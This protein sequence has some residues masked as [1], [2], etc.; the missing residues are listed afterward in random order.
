[1]GESGNVYTHSLVSIVLI[2]A[3]TVTCIFLPYRQS[4]DQVCCSHPNSF[5]DR[6][7]S[8][9]LGCLCL[10]TLLR[11]SP[12][13]QDCACH[14]CVCH[15]GSW[16]LCAQATMLAQQ[17]TCMSE[18]YMLRNREVLQ[19]LVWSVRKLTQTKEWLGFSEFVNNTEQTP[20]SNSFQNNLMQP[21]HCFEKI[22]VDGKTYSVGFANK[23]NNSPTFRLAEATLGFLWDS[24]ACL[25]PAIWGRVKVLTGRLHITLCLWCS[26]FLSSAMVHA[27]KHCGAFCTN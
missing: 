18:P 14:M 24:T 10:H 4:M 6:C 15:L 5:S 1:M 9:L 25:K 27:L 3:W 8:Q 20:S 16:W 7:Q 19:N 23:I 11:L 21:T 26:S 12:V 2:H 17:G 22:S 13:I